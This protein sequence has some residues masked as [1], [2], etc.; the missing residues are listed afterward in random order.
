MKSSQNIIES[1]DPTKTENN[2]KHVLKD[3]TWPL[4]PFQ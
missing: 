3:Q 2:P 4:D 1:I